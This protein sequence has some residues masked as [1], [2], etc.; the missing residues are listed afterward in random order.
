M[1]PVM[2]VGSTLS[3]SCIH[4][5][6]RRP[7]SWPGN[8]KAAVHAPSSRTRP[9]T[10]H[11]SARPPRASRSPLCPRGCAGRRASPVAPRQVGGRDCPPSVQAW[12]RL[13][14]PAHQQ[15][16]CS[17]PSSPPPAGAGDPPSRPP[18]RPPSPIV[19]DFCF[20]QPTSPAQHPH[21]AHGDSRPRQQSPQSRHPTRCDQRS[22]SPDT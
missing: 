18:W 17:P 15:W 2:I 22:R 19:C 5:R 20:P 1:R 4:S 14:Q 6:K 9:R 3:S 16:P 13:M 11:A 10:A 8:S 12:P 21:A 7:A